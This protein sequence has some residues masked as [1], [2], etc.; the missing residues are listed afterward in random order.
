[1]TTYEC[2]CVAYPRPIERVEAESSFDARKAYAERH[3]CDVV[4]VIARRIDLIDKQWSDHIDRKR[5]TIAAI[6]GRH[7][8]SPEAV[9]K[10][11]AASNRS[12]RRI[13]HK[14][15]NAIHRLLK[16]R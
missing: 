15:A 16:G 13:G 11:I 4:D 2:S 12:G 6:E 3:G 5:A 1:M 7:G 8:Y 9:N 14:E 10:A